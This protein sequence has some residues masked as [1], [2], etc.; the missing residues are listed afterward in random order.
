MRFLADENFPGAGV[1]ALRR[2]GHDVLSIGEVSRGANDAA[3][4]DLATREGR[5]I[6]SFDK[7]FGELARKS[8][9][10]DACGVI[11]FRMPLSAPAAA[12]GERVAKLVAARDDWAGHFSVIEPGR[13]RM[14]RM[15]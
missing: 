5:I 15:G 9:L 2:R 14:R 1:A 6:L 8:R 7:D 12:A 4:L 3:V 11:L 13:V 10:P